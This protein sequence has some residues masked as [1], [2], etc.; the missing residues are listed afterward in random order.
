[1]IAQGGAEHREFAFI[2]ATHDVQA[3]APLADVI[4]GDEFFG[5]DQRRDQRRMHRQDAHLPFLAWKSDHIHIFG[6]DLASR[7][8]DFEFQAGC[9]GVVRDP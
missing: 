8:G 9:H 3:K 1:M 7:S 5:G 2:R 4:G 6:I